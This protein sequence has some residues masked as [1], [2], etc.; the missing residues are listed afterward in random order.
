MIIFFIADFSQLINW[1]VKVPNLNVWFC[2]TKSKDMWLH[3]IEDQEKQQILTLKAGTCA[4][5]GHFCLK[6]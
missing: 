4:F 6:K 3:I 1:S 2:Q 5:L